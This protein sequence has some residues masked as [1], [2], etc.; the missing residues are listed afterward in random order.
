[1]QDFFYPELA[2][3]G[4]LVAKVATFK[5][6]VSRGFRILSV[7]V[8]TILDLECSCP[9]DSRFGMLLSRGFQICNTP[10]QRI[11][12]LEY[13]RPED[14]RFGVLLSRGF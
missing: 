1:M 8:Q 6:L 4:Y 7:P 14:S 2:R 5:I 10:V 9:E 3:F 12:D 11:P 13:S